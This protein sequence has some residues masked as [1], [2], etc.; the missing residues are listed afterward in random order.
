MVIIVLMIN[1]RLNIYNYVQLA[2]NNTRFLNDCTFL[3]VR[4]WNFIVL[5]IGTWFN[6][7][8]VLTVNETYLRN[9]RVK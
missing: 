9:A 6:L 8:T 3:I 1:E 4:H 2:D 5:V 7:C